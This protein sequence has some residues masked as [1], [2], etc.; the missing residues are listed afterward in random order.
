[1]RARR[2]PLF[3]VDPLSIKAAAL[4]LSCV[5]RWLTA[6][7]GPCSGHQAHAHLPWTPDRG[8]RPPP[9]SLGIA[10]G[11]CIDMISRYRAPRII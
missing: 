10:H 1:M 2:R 8:G 7:I 5:R 9:G 4:R 11:E 6:D 3:S